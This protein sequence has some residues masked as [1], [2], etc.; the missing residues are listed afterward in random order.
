MF[1]LGAKLIV[2]SKCRKYFSKNLLIASL[3]MRRLVAALSVSGTMYCR[4]AAC[5]YAGCAWPA[6][7]SAAVEQKRSTPN[8][9]VER[10]AILCIACGGGGSRTQTYTT[11]FFNNLFPCKFLCQMKSPTNSCISCSCDLY[12]AKVCKM[13]K[14]SKFHASKFGEID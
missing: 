9:G 3:N 13:R 14:P 1:C 12:Y 4:C 10:L 11:L 5:G 2:W 6:P 8:H 7:L